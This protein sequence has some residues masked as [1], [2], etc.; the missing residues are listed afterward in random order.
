MIK[1]FL[2]TAW[3]KCNVCN[4]ISDVA[5]FTA[6]TSITQ[7]PSSQNVIFE[8]RDNLSCSL[9]NDYIMIHFIF[10]YIWERWMCKFISMQDC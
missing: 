2:L 7:I 10:K 4:C 1:H 3:V 8:F 6:S 9:Q 5:F